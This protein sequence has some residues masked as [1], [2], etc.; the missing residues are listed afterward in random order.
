M[1]RVARREKGR[2]GGREGGEGENAAL[3]WLSPFP[4]VEEEGVVEERTKKGREG[5]REGGKGGKI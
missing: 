3:D 5:G 4:A 2:E 1:E